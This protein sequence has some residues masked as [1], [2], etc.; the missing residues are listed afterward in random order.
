[1]LDLANFVVINKSDLAGARTAA[2][3][4][5]QRLRANHA[6]QQVISTVSKH[7]RD[8]GVDRLFQMLT[9][10]SLATETPRTQRRP[11]TKV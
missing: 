1:M 10:K 5:E 2:S 3:E 9:E 6:N 11:K 4:V 8:S 7:H